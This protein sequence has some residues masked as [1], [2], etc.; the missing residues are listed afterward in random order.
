MTEQRNI[1]TVF[2]GE[3]MNET[4]IDYG[5]AKEVVSDVRV[6]RAVAELMMD[7]GAYRVRDFENPSTFFTY[8]S[9][10]RAPIY[11]DVRLLLDD[12]RMRSFVSSCLGCVITYQFPR[13]KLIAGVADGAP[14]WV[15]SIADKFPHFQPAY[16]RKHVKEHG[17]EPWFLTPP[18]VGATAVLVDDLMNT[19]SATRLGVDRLHEVGAKVLGVVS[20]VNWAQT[21]MFARLDEMQIKPL[22]L[23][24]WPWII[25][26]AELRNVI[27]HRQ[28][29]LLA[30]FYSSMSTFNWETQRHE[31]A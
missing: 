22:A 7:C 14:P 4:T 1:Q 19:G 21:E 20:V 18:P 26:A 31:S 16:I 25:E 29:E 23:T 9:G 11:T 30:D 17:T 2:S 3:A 13:V 15:T 27:T 8:A 5:T 28:S 12:V 10:I 6:A 24:S